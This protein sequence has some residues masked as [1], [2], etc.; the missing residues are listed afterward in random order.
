MSGESRLTHDFGNAS[1]H[2]GTNWTSYQVS[3]APGEWTNLETGAQPTATEL[4]AALADLDALLI[5]GEYRTGSD[6]GG[7]DNVEL[8]T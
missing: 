7:I 4:E 6:T 1:T 5:R 3:L 8:S 2:P